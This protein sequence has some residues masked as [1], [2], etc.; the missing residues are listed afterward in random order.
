MDIDSYLADLDEI[1]EDLGWSIQGYCLMP[2]HVHLMGRLSKPN[3]S[4]GMQ[5][6]HGK[7][8]SRFN[9][10][11]NRSGHVFQGRFTA[12]IVRSDRH[13]LELTRYH[14]MNP[15]RARLRKR[16]EQWPFGSYRHV[17]G[18]G[19]QPPEFLDLDGLLARFGPTRR[20]GIRRV[21]QFVEDGLAS[22]ALLTER[23]RRG[24]TRV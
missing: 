5:R 2:N 23:A 19:G 16:P 3:L 11:H 22:H 4:E 10:R 12:E 6:L 7:H 21:Q 1:A 15:V 17:V 8:G 18:V 13:A 9:R 20:V 24:Q 14:A